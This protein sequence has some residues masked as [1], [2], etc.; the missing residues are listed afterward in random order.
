MVDSKNSIRSQLRELFRERD[1]YTLIRP[2]A[3][4]KDLQTLNTIPEARLRP[5]FVSAV[6]GL[7]SVLRERI[8]PKCFKSKP[9]SPV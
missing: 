3:N 5:E 8:K 1:C 2:T 4:E 6:R 7:K 9:C